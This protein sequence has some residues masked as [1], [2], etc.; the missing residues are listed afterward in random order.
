MK[1]GG[2][3]FQAP[4]RGVPCSPVLDDKVCVR[5]EE[6]LGEMKLGKK[7]GSGGR[8]EVMFWLTA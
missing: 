5:R 7:C 1:I 3:R 2:S 4:L 6:D 8:G